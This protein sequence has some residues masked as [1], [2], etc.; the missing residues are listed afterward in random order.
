[1][2]YSF[3]AKNELKIQRLDNTLMDKNERYVT[4]SASNIGWRGLNA[5]RVQHYYA[6]ANK[7]TSIKFTFYM[8]LK[9]V[10]LASDLK[11]LRE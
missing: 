11:L 6:S 5:G 3:I 1:M 10:E 4:W 7:F 2:C 9:V 8:S